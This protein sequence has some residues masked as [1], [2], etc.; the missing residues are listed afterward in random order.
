MTP[1]TRCRLSTADCR[2]RGSAQLTDNSPLV[3]A[4]PR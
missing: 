1:E 3:A 2:Q 4:E